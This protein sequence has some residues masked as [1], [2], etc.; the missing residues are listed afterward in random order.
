MESRHCILTAQVEPGSQ[1]RYWPEGGE[2]GQGH[3]TALTGGLP[4]QPSHVPCPWEP[5]ELLRAH[6]RGGVALASALL[7]AFSLL[8]ADLGMFPPLRDLAHALAPWTIPLRKTQT[9]P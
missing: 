3:A 2:A 8:S 4:S 5:W 1:P 7:E 6:G 9:V